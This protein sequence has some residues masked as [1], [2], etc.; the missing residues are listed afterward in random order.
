MELLSHCSPPGRQPANENPVVKDV[1]DKGECGRCVFVTWRAAGRLLHQPGR[2]EVCHVTLMEAGFWAVDEM[3]R[4]QKVDL[5]LRIRAPGRTC[6][7]MTQKS[8]CYMVAWLHLPQLRRDGCVLPSVLV[9]QI[10]QQMCVFSDLLQN[11]CGKTADD[12]GS[13]Y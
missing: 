8:F 10:W 1:F 9:S 6:A 12:T 3:S 13:I 5:P 11:Q 2:D 7:R 4:G